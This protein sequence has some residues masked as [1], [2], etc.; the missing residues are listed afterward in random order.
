MLRNPTT[1]DLDTTPH[2]SE[3]EAGTEPVSLQNAGVNHVEGGWPKDVDTEDAD[4]K[5][6]YRKKV[7]KGIAD[8]DG[9]G[10]T[11][12]LGENMKLLGPLVDRCLRQNNTID[13]YEEY[14]DGTTVEHSSEPPSAKGLAKFRDPNEMKR[15]A[16]S[17]N[18]NPDNPDKIA[19]SYSIMNFQD[20][21]FMNDRMPVDSYLW[22]INNPN[23]PEVTLTPASALC[24]LRYNKN[25]DTLVGGCYNGLITFF[26]IRKR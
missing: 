17:I 12:S 18:W 22:D 13:I 26:D 14:F 8:K 16:T 5:D 25:P 15:T 2:Y 3:H 9:A 21:R 20:P 19:V 7:E 24:C 11:Q 23:V 6:R 1:I 10:G 4:A